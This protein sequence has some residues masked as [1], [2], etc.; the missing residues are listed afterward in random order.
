MGRDEQGFTV[1]EVMIAMVLSM[2]ASASI[3]GVLV[4]QNNAEKRATDFTV[5]QEEAR[6][7]LVY[8]QRDLRSAEPIVGVTQVADYAYQV[9][10]DVYD[11]IDA[12]IPVKVSWKLETATNTL[13]RYVINADG[14]KTSTY[15]IRGVV[16]DDVIQPLFRYY[17]DKNIGTEGSYDILSQTAAPEVGTVAYCTVRV[18]ID[19]RA[20]P[21]GSPAPVRLE[22]DVML[23]NKLPGAY[24]C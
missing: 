23:R 18:K 7:A 12:E 15:S 13:H 8:L 24:E 22:S 5:N 19:L 14:T 4:S 16:N 2:L 20:A 10:L 6:Q 9:D 11:A 3:M 1:V 21:N 17:N